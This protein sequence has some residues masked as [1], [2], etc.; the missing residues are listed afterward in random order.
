[1][2]SY[3]NKLAIDVV[4]DAMSLRDEGGKMKKL[5][6]FGEFFNTQLREIS[7]QS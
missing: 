3:A 2:M 6:S 4:N 5:K 7:A 1:M